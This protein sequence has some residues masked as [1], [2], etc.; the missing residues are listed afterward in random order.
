MCIV[1]RTLPAGTNLDKSCCRAGAAERRAV[2]HSVVGQVAAS[3]QAGVVLFG[4]L[5][6]RGRYLGWVKGRNVTGHDRDNDKR[7]PQTEPRNPG[8]V[9][10]T[11]LGCVTAATGCLPSHHPST[12]QPARTGEWPASIAPGPDVQM[13]PTFP[14]DIARREGGVGQEPTAFG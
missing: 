9:L 1:S 6:P 13:R 8:R 3:S 10:K 4:R 11:Q 7:N 12:M 2:G 5:F 14:C